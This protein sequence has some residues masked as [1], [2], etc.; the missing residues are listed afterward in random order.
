M[1]ISLR[2]LPAW[3]ISLWL[4]LS[5][6]TIWNQNTLGANIN[7]DSGTAGRALL[8]G[9]MVSSVVYLLAPVLGR[10]LFVPTHASAMMGMDA[11]NALQESIGTSVVRG[12]ALVGLYLLVWCFAMQFG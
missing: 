8:S 1:R 2:L 9:L 12:F 4:L 7:G 6:E 3:I 5:S 10:K 11:P